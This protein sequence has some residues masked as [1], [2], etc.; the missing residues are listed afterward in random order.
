[1]GGCPHSGGA[2]LPLTPAFWQRQPAATGGATQPSVSPHWEL[3]QGERQLSPTPRPQIANS[4]GALMA[5][6]IHSPPLSSA[7]GDSHQ[8]AVGWGRGSDI[9]SILG[10]VREHTPPAGLGQFRQASSAP[11]PTSPSTEQRTSVWLEFSLTNIILSKVHFLPGAFWTSLLSHKYQRQE[12]VLIHLGAKS[13]QQSLPF[14]W[15]LEIHHG[16]FHVHDLR[17]LSL[18]PLLLLLYIIDLT[19]LYTQKRRD[20]MVSTSDKMATQLGVLYLCQ[21]PSCIHSASLLPL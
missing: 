14:C 10:G 12:D 19:Q 16:L 3:V 17:F 6:G 1:M 8:L 13:T 9:H 15:V 20:L 7:V 21:N 11:P 18:S 2:P 5:G 4:G